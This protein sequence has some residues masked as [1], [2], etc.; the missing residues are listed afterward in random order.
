M[1]DFRNKRL[2]LDFNYLFL[3]FLKRSWKYIVLVF[4]SKEDM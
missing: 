3:G 1:Y 4:C 2:I